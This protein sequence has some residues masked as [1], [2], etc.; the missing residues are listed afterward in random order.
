M[1]GNKLE[2]ILNDL[3]FLD[4]TEPNINADYNKKKWWNSPFSCLKC[5][6]AQKWR[7]FCNWI[8]GSKY[9]RYLS[10]LLV[11]KL[12]LEEGEEKGRQGPGL[13]PRKESFSRDII[14]FY[15]D[16]KLNTT[17][18]LQEIEHQISLRRHYCESIFIDQ[19]N[20]IPLQVTKPTLIFFAYFISNGREHFEEIEKR[21]YK[22]SSSIYI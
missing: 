22:I 12:I 8:T 13:I 19:E 5:W 10:L 20:V 1:Q 11:Y 21:V 14:L 6:L 18:A 7:D 4:L 15:N 3:L 2:L 9:S 17:D 16:L